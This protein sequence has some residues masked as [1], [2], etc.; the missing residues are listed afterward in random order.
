MQSRSYRRDLGGALRR[1]GLI[2]EHDLYFHRHHADHV[3]TWHHLIDEHAASYDI[4]VEH[5]RIVWSARRDDEH[6]Q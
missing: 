4:C 3:R 5:G 2:A 6:E 1:L